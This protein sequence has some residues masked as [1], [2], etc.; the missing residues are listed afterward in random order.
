MIKSNRLV[1][2]RF[3]EEHLGSADYLQWLRDLDNLKS[4]NLTGYILNRVEYNDLL[5]YYRKFCDQENDL[6]FSITFTETGRFIGTATL[7]E[8]GYKGLYDIGILIGDKSFRGKGL[9]RE[10]ISCITEYAFSSKG[11]RK[12]CSSFSEKNIPVMLAF[13]KNGYK[14]EGLQRDQQLSVDGELENRY[15][16]GLLKNDYLC[17]LA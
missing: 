6:L 3:N 5:E 12:I 7:R 1:I 16:V 13:L 17:D 14:I 11:A 15:V 8:I 9:A 4:L 10:A 2:D